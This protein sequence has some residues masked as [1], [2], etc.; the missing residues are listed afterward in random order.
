MTPQE[1]RH[2]EALLA[3]ERERLSRAEVELVAQ[4]QAIVEASTH[5]N[6]DD[7]HD[8]EGATIGFERARAASLL[9]HVRGRLSEIDDASER[10]RSG[11]YGGCERCSQPIPFERVA[12]HPTARRCVGCTDPR[13]DESVGRDGSRLSPGLPAR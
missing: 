5:A 9:C 6:L 3:A 8:P 11:A 2:I 10:L 7:E 13:A 12:A 4:H 1:R